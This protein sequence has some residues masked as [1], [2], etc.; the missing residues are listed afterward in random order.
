MR[1]FVQ[2]LSP[3]A[4][5]SRCH[6]LFVLESARVRRLL[7]RRRLFRMSFTGVSV[8]FLIALI[9]WLLAVNADRQHYSYPMAVDQLMTLLLVASI[10]ADGFLDF[11]CMVASVNSFAGEI[12]AGRWDLLRLTPYRSED[13]A[14][15]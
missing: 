15:V 9:F 5:V 2:Q 8:I 7:D 13:F 12:V 6:P 1:A 10:G 3:Y 4:S 11:A 14:A